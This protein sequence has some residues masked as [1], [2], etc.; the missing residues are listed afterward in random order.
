ML[1]LRKYQLKVLWKPGKEMFIADALSRNYIKE[2]DDE[3]DSE[4][5]DVEVN[6]MIQNLPVSAAK[7]SEFQSETSKDPQAKG[8]K[9]TLLKGSFKND[10]P[11]QIWKF[12][13]TR[14]K[15]HE[16]K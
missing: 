9:E 10:Y 6:V 13:K 7:Y 8:L 3:L 14:L 5:Y 1:G 4:E 12:S 11:Y 16:K 15:T 2:T